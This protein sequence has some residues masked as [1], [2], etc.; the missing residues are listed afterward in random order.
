MP[1]PNL[2]TATITATY[3]DYTGG[4][5]TGKVTF[6]PQN[7]ATA[8]AG[9]TL[10]LPKAIV[11]TLNGSGAISQVLPVGDVDYVSEITYL[12]DEQIDGQ[13]GKYG[14]APFYI[15]LTSADANDTVDLVS[16]SQTAP[17]TAYTDLATSLTSTFTRA[18]ALTMA[19]AGVVSALNRKHRSTC[20]QVIGD[21]TGD[22]YNNGS[23]PDVDEWPQVLTRLLQDQYPEYSLIQRHWN[24]ANQNYDPPVTLVAG[25]G[26]TA[27][28]AGDRHVVVDLASPAGITTTGAAITGDID[29]RVK[30]LLPDWT[31]TGQ[32]TIAS[33]WYTT[34]NQR[35][36]IL[37][38]NTAG[39]ISLAW[40]TD[41]TSGTLTTKTSTAPVPFTDGAAG[42]I[43]ATVDV[44]N[45]ATGNDVKFYTSTDGATWTQLGTTVTT[46]GVTSIFGGTAPYQ[47][48]SFSEGYSNPM[49]GRIYWTEVYAGLNGGAS[50]VPPL[51]DDWEVV[52]ALATATYGG[53]PVLMLLNGSA[54]GQN[55]TYFDDVSRRGAISHPHGQAVILLS[56]SHN[57]TSSRHLWLTRYTD[58]VGHIKSL[59]PGVPIVVMGQNPVGLGGPFNITQNHMEMRGA[60]AS[61]VHTWAASQAGVYPFDAYLSMTAADTVDQLHPSRG[62]G[63]GSDKW[64]RY[65]FARIVRS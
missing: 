26:T 5:C 19:F 22:G 2:S 60:R 56:T 58:W 37:S 53:A 10:L 8:S 64:G 47:L 16:R 57:D 46:A 39:T 34:G 33:K 28:G 14:R 55:V 62:D 36:W 40:T 23:G 63:S 44:D 30:A 25:T 41:G 21:S 18:P 61:L 6:T 43:R 11:A 51:P 9:G 31:P 59:T 20:I 32:R 4:A 65:M 1:V 48:C 24:H 17:S 12:V 52:S 15:T 50:V 3:L 54:S 27:S 35:S 13:A 49:S 38:V 42:W 29:V 45:G 7:T